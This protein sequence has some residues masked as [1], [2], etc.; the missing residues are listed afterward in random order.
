MQTSGRSCP[1]RHHAPAFT[2]HL[3]NCEPALSVATE[4]ECAEPAE[5]RGKISAEG[6]FV[7]DQ[8]F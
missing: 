2:S 1:D 5:V 4:D 7:H 8:H 3:S 6:A